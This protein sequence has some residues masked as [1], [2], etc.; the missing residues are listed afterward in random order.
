[1][2]MK[3]FNKAGMAVVYMAAVLF[4]SVSYAKQEVDKPGFYPSVSATYTSEDNVFRQPTIEISDSALTLSPELLFINTFGKHQF[5]AEYVGEFASYDKRSTENYAD[6]SLV[7]D[8]LYDLSR[9][10]NVELQAS[11]KKGHE[12]RA[13]SG[14]VFTDINEWAE[15]RVFARF[16][17]GRKTAKAR[18]E[19]DVALSDLEYTNNNQSSRDRKTTEVS[20][21]AL[22]NVGSKTSIFGELKRNTYNYVNPAVQNFDSVEEFYHV[23]VRW[24]ATNKTAG[25][26]KVGLFS[27]DF[28]SAAE[29]NGDDISYE[30]TIL[31]KPKTYS[32]FT[33]G[34]SSE[35]KE[36]ITTDSFYTRS[37][38][39][40][41]WDHSFNSRLSLNVNLK[42]GE[43]DFTG[44]RKDDLSN[45]G[46]GI[47]YKFRRWLDVGLNYTTEKRDSTDNTMD[48]TNNS[49]MLMVKL[50]K[51]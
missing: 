32:H 51:H 36:T 8:V 1:M 2:F 11:Y 31:W 20:A 30:A 13:T 7:L 40:L 4:S 33:L 39:S 5:T 15:N 22:Y 43:D 28:D 47:N 23:G 50:S 9:K 29:T 3:D 18:L 38:V 37:V 44:T 41:N 34:F 27:K 26:F 46:I 45:A 24:D 48:Y 14:I 19:F 42:E 6:H 21:R 16:A 10:F 25:M 35:P 12:S 49:F 17:Y